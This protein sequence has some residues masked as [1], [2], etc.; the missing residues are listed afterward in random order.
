LLRQR[1]DR[2]AEKARKEAETAK[3]EEVTTLAGLKPWREV[4]SPHPDV[5]GG[6]YLQAE[7]VADLSQ[8]VA[9]NAEIEYQDPNE[10]FRRTYLTEGLEEM[11]VTGIK[12]LTAQ[13]GDPVVQL[14]ASFGGGKTHSM[15]ALYHLCSG[16][17]SL[18]DIPGG[19]RLARRVNDVDLPEAN[20]A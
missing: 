20:R 18:D 14:K 1:Y 16:D 4:V 10:F 6:R 7:F 2:E 17:L 8:V 19:E 5:A 13:G 3:T 11:L 9:G 15:L 12:R